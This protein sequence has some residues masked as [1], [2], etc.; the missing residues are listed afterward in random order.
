[1]YIVRSVF[2]LRLYFSF[3]AVDTLNDIADDL[4]Y[5][6][7]PISLYIQWIAVLWNMLNLQLCR[8]CN[9][10]VIAVPSHT[11]VLISDMTVIMCAHFVQKFF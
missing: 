9:T 5:K 1:M 7:L 4:L 6:L 11:L 3:L 8:S 2:V 10:A